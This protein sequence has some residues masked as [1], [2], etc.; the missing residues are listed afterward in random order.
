MLPGVTETRAE[1]KLARLLSPAN[2]AAVAVLA[3]I[4]AKLFGQK[5]SDPDL[6][7]H[8]RT[9]KLIAATHSLPRADIYSFTVPG[10]RW[11]VQEW[12]SE[13]ILHAI[14]KAG[15]LYGILVWR[16]AMLLVIYILVARLLTRRMG[17]GIGTWAL[18]ALVAYSGSL[19][20]TERPNLFSFLLFVVTLDLL[21][22]RSRAVWWFVPL[23]AL[24]ANLHGMVIIGIGLVLVVAAAEALKVVLHWEGAD[25]LWA[26][27]LGLVAGGG[28]LAMMLNPSGPGLLAHAFSLIGTVSR[29]ITEWASPDFH[30]LGTF[31]F[32]ILLIVTIA[33]LALTPERPDPT[34]IALALAFI[35]LALSAVRNLTMA[36]IV[37]GLVAARAV[38][39]ALAA[40]RPRARD[41]AEMAE[42]SSVVLGATALIATLGIL[43]LVAV[44]GFPPSQRPNV[45]ISKA[46][47]VSAIDALRRPGVRVFSLDLWA[48]LV[49]DRNYPETKVFMDTR[50]DMY[51]P[52]LARRYI[53]IAGAGRRWAAYLDRPCTTHVLVRR[54]DSIAQ[55]LSLSPDWRV[56]REDKRSVTFARREPAP[57]C[58]RF[59]IP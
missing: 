32:F 27:R 42:R 41:R 34:D 33:A 37:L 1:S 6:W 50:V 12:G 59:T 53:E 18:L 3:S 15:G 4:P 7:W 23:A 57:G 25:P 24:W 19:S 51:G 10:K 14:R 22:R 26:R 21:E 20:W 48:G 31:P 45:I 2:V 46:Y 17:T 43:G 54:R 5:L 28:T 52:A 13:L 35:T 47:P 44:S 58:E 56:E 49:I 30:E 40:A 9:G 8:L 29:I 11:V 39:P 36:A 55:V 16:A 38:P